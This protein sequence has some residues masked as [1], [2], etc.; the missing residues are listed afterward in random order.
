[1]NTTDRNAHHRRADVL[2]AVVEAANARRD[3][4]LPTDLAG[5]RETFD[6]DFALAAALQTRWHTRL[7]GRIERQ[8]ADQPADL[9][10]A[11]LQAWRD[12]ARDLVGVR[13]ILDVLTA[14]PTSPAMG[15]ALE[16]ARRKDWVLLAAMAGRAGAADARALHVG[17]ALED[18]A[19]A[20][21][22]PGAVPRP[23]A[24]DHRSASLLGRLKAV[25]AA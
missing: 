11:V 9:E 20:A 23:A 13:E 24:G 16:R 1:M 22:D 8:L 4:V 10:S 21:H 2:R 6:D 14:A 15:Q 19:R 25:L 17:R 7:S 18:R 12:T 3:G 5:V